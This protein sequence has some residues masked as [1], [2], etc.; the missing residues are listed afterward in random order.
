[1]SAVNKAKKKPTFRVGLAL[2][3]LSVFGVAVIVLGMGTFYLV[4]RL[5]KGSVNVYKRLP[6][7][8]FGNLPATLALVE[9][10]ESGS[11]AELFAKVEP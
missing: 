6:N 4:V 9:D 8:T 7:P 3:V 2:A 5:R 1:M 11:E 10:S